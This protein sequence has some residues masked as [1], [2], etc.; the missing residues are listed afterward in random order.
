MKQLYLL[1]LSLII[2]FTSKAQLVK[3]YQLYYE[4]NKYQLTSQQNSFLDSIIKSLPNIPEGYMV[5]VKGHT[6]N[7]G[8]LE[9]NNTLSRNRAQEVLNYLKNRHFMDTDTSMNYFAFNKPR[10]ENTDENRWQN[11]RVEIE[12]YARRIDMK[13]ALGINDFKPKNY[14]LNEDSGG[15]ILHDSTKITIEANS[16][17]F[18]DGSEVSGEID[19]IYQEFRTP[20]DFIL[21]GI[22]MSVN[23]NNKLEH[24][25]SAGMFDISAT[26][27]GKKLVLKNDSEKTVKLDFPLTDFDQQNFYNLNPQ[28]N[29]WNSNFQPITDAHG[30]MLPPFDVLQPALQNSKADIERFYACMPTR[31]T[32]A[33]VTYMVKK[34]RYFLN[35][36]E[37]INMNEP[38]KF[39]KDNIVQY[40]SPIYTVKLDEKSRTI[41]LIPLTKNNNLGVF[42]NYMWTYS[43]SDAKNDLKN[44]FR[45]GCLHVNIK[46]SGKGF[47]LKLDNN[48]LR[49]T[50]VPKNYDANLLKKSTFSFG[51][52]K[53]V[54]RFEAKVRR[55]NK[56]NFKTYQAQ[57]QIIKQEE[58][59]NDIF[60]N[61]TAGLPMVMDRNAKSTWKDSLL[62]MDYFYKAFLYNL[63]D[64]TFNS[65]WDFN[66]NKKELKE[67]MNVYPTPF[68]CNKNSIRQLL[69]KRD[70]IN[71][72]Y[73][74]KTDSADKMRRS[75][76]AR[77]GINATGTFNADAVK[78]IDAPEQIYASYKAQD[79][80]SL[81]II[82]I[83]VSIDNLNGIINYNGYMDYGPYKFVYSK[84][85]R[86]MMIAVDDKENSYYCIPEEFAAQIKNK[87]GD[88]VTFTLKPLKN[89]GTT[90]NLEKLVSK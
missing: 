18:E 42:T 89:L 11:R 44:A 20:S 14:R 37:P 29:Q 63:S 22:P 84:K 81:K 83:Y 64:K 78:S 58:K 47:K 39:V 2:H 60:L 41:E 31:D 69:V 34:I 90:E 53:E 86:C 17:R 79:G 28:T 67:K 45:N 59:K 57:Q 33:Y 52:K 1:L 30:N 10:T 74:A 6:D 9:L 40:N 19:V 12:I 62:C 80:T 48:E 61:E 72:I 43:K 71:R 49:V 54:K 73:I 5:Q 82:S 24:F 16:F 23:R 46:R 27:N 21:S 50:G 25:N 88:S 15:V 75:S 38:Y 3:T 13:K 55:L 8:S 68:V 70:S 26:Q 56:S 76:F 4:T 35:H 32:C 66:L 85:R 7:K 36:D 51:S 87:T 65:I 77:F